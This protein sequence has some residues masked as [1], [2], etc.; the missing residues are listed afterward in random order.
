M[1]FRDR[2]LTPGVA[3]ALT[4]PS[5]ILLAGAGT[6]LG[7]LAGLPIVGAA[8]I[9]AAAYAARVALAIPRRQRERIDLRIVGDPWRSFV[10]E[11]LDARRRYDRA[12]QAVAAGPLRE[13]LA[14]IGARL[15]DGVDE[16]WRIALRGQALK[17]A[18]GELEPSDAIRRELQQVRRERTR[19]R[20]S[21]HLDATEQALRAQLESRERIA[22]VADETRERLRLLNARLDEAVARAVELALQASDASDL[23]GLGGDVDALVGEMEALRQALEEASGASGGSSSL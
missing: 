13:R 10:R 18:L 17:R 8:A 15:D 16:C 9:G 23:G 2:F 7:I 20:E 14:E 21:S 4:S 6:S 3:R 19:D 12:V 5:G 11:A 1:G 22:A